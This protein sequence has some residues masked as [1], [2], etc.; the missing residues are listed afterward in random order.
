M[1]GFA[2]DPLD[3]SA[4]I[5][6]DRWSEM[7]E[8]AYADRYADQDAE[9]REL[10]A[11]SAAQVELHRRVDRRRE[12][13]RRDQHAEHRTRYHLRKASHRILFPR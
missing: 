6:Q 9:D 2:F 10:L 7:N 12:C 8:E 1:I 4:F 13:G 3:V 5:D 11:G